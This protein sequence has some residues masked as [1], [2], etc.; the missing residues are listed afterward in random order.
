MDMIRFFMEVG[1]LKKLK[2]GGWLLDGI[3]NSETIADHLF[4]TALMV[5]I[6]GKNARDVDLL[7]AIKMALIHDL[8]ESQ[9]GDLIVEDKVKIMREYGNN[10][11]EIE[12]LRKENI[13]IGLENDERERIEEVAVK[14]LTK[15]S[16]IDEIYS[17]WREFEDQKTPEALFVKQ[18]DRLEMALQAMEYESE[19][20]DKILEHYFTSKYGA[21]SIMKDPELV[22]LLRNIMSLRPK[23]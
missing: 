17:L 13:N 21:E 7:K 1:N 5:F 2:R 16:G 10:I 11:T 18:I 14:K 9:T 19:N 4:R 22:K 23:K 8:G 6:L 3:K 12:N 15:L 20:N